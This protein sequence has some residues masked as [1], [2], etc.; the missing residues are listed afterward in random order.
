MI[1]QFSDVNF[2]L[3]LFL[4]FFFFCGIG[5]VFDTNLIQGFNGLADILHQFHAVN[6]LL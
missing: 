5:I 6:W 4:L 3:F 2:V 1:F